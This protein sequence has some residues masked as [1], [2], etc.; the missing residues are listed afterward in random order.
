MVLATDSISPRAPAGLRA[1]GHALPFALAANEHPDLGT[2]REPGQVPPDGFVQRVLRQRTAQRLAECHELLELVRPGARLFGFPAR[3]CRVGAH[4][5]PVRVQVKHEHHAQN[6][7]RRNQRHTVGSLDV[8][9]HAEQELER[10]LE[11][12]QQGEG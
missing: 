4:L 10:P 7:Q 8:A 1:V 9:G 2:G 6:Q 11:D 5:A 12:D 3:R